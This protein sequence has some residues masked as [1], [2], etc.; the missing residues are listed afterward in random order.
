MASIPGR[1]LATPLG[2]APAR[3]APPSHPTSAHAQDFAIGQ[4]EGFSGD[5]EGRRK[6]IESA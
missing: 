2:V 4:G 6:R 3:G 1:A 5:L